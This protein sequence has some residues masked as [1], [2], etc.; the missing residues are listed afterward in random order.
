MAKSAGHFA[1]EMLPGFFDELWVHDIRQSARP[2][3]DDVGLTDGLV[4]SIKEKG[5]LQPIIVRPTEDAFEVIAG[6]R[7]LK[8][9]RRLGMKKIPCYVVGLDDKQAYEIS[10]IENIQRRSL[11]PIEEAKAFRRYV[12]EG[13]YGAVS[14]LASKI[15]KSEPFVS[16]RLALLS[17]PSEVQEQLIRRRITLSIAEELIPLDPDDIRE[18][19][20]QPFIS[21]ATRAEVRTAIKRARES[22]EAKSVSLD[23]NYGREESLRRIERA[24]SKCIASMSTCLMQI[25]DAI[26]SLGENEWF[27]KENLLFHRTTIHQLIDRMITLRARKPQ[28]QRLI[29]QF[30][31]EEARRKQIAR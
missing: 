29:G 6:N 30:T 31:Q 3:R 8:A 22:R 10:L 15:G 24:R 26:G 19:A 28:T 23:S 2:L 21:Q 14:E 7:R 18:L 25:D 16:K 20:G 5:V 13:G 17:L 1:S 11:D 12:D 4:H 9:C 27:S